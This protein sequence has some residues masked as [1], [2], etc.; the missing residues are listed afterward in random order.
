MDYRKVNH[1]TRKDAYLLPRIDD[2]L[3]TLAGSTWFSTLDMFSGYWQVQV[4]ESDKEKTAFSTRDGLFHFNVLPFGLCNGPATFQR[5]MD[6][7]LSN[8]HWSSCLVNLDVVIV[9]GKSFDE[10]LVNLQQVFTC[11][12]QANLK[13]KPSKCQLCQNEVTLLGH[14]VSAEGVTADPT[15]T[16]KVRDWPTPTSQHQL[17]QFL[18]LASYYRRFVKDFVS[19]CRPLHRLLEKGVCFNWTTDCQQTF[20]SLRSHLTSLPILAFFDFSKEFIL[21]TDASDTH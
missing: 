2:T 9:L 7:I 6:S 16:D 11:L 18:G 13:I 4:T 12:H 17:R 20:D 3:D 1:L 5:L 14:I 15:K 10:H 21:D 8:L 19:I